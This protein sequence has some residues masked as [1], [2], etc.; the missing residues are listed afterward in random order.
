MPSH[1]ANI[2]YARKV[3]NG[4]RGPL[5][6]LQM[7]REA[8]SVCKPEDP[9]K[10]SLSALTVTLLQDLDCVS[11]FQRQPVGDGAS[12]AGDDCKK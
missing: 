6:E 10:E 7:H 3:R 5:E 12:E 8:D 2:E 9:P 11:N 4:S 1:T